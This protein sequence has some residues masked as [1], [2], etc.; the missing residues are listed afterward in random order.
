MAM[1]KFL[2]LKPEDGEDPDTLSFNMDNLRDSQ[3]RLDCCIMYYVYEKVIVVGGL[4]YW[5]GNPPE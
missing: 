2:N 3:M 4:L 1:S 5:N